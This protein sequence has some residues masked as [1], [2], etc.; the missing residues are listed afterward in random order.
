MYQRPER[1]N[2]VDMFS[3]GFQVLSG[4]VA[5]TRGDWGI[6]LRKI[7]TDRRPPLC[8]VVLDLLQQ[9]QKLHVESSPIFGL[10]DQIGCERIP[11]YI[12][13]HRIEVLVILNRKRFES[14]LVNVTGAGALAMG[15]PA[16]GVGEREPACEAG[17]LTVFTE[18][19]D[20][21]PM[22]RHHSITEQR[23]SNRSTASDKIRSKAA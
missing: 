4:F 9:A 17:E 16:L 5:E 11:F 18:M 3:L 1:T 22:V 2:Q 6:C 7:E 13:A 12:P 14:S 23:I 15:V 20:Q 10:L 19:N 8:A 21:M